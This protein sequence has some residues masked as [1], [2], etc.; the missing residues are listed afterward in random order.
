MTLTKS[1]TDAAMLNSAQESD[2]VTQDDIVSVTKRNTSSAHPIDCQC[3][4]CL[5]MRHSKERN[6]AGVKEGLDYFIGDSSE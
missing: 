5:E 6:E 3:E 1:E 4:V 2:K